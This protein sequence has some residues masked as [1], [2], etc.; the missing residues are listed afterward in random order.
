[1]QVFNVTEEMLPASAYCL[2]GERLV[3]YYYA[4]VEVHQVSR[5]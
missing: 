4:F 2:D 1:M 5:D 3:L